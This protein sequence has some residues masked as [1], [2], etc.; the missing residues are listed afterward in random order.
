MRARRQRFGVFWWTWLLRA[1]QENGEA[2]ALPL[3]RLSDHP[4]SVGVRDAPHDRQAQAGAAPIS[5]C[6]PIGVE[7]A[8]QDI[9]GDSNDRVLDLE[10][11]LRA[12]VD[13][14]HDDASAARGKADRVGA[15]VDH[16]L[17]E[18]FLVAEVCEVRPVALALEGDTRLLGLWV[19]LLDAAGHERREVKRLTVELHEPGAEARHL[20]DL[21]GEPEQPL[22]ALSD[23]AGE[24]PLLLRERA[25]SALVKEVDGAADRR[26]RRAELV[27]DRREELALRLLHLAQLAR[28]RVERAR[29]SPDLVAAFDRDG[30]T[31]RARG[32][33][34]RGGGQ[35]IEGASHPPSDDRRHDEREG[36]RRAERDQ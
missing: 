1:R 2:A 34:R 4:T 22:G 26:E 29:E 36:D 9:G 35:Q 27:G 21:I 28:H 14:P 16:E 13:D 30:L 31:K 8:R 20:E 10:V 19:K 15:E 23:D 5:V 32:D 18:P 6:L 24:T 25:G 11:E 12:R 17:V 33:L 7:D 3:A